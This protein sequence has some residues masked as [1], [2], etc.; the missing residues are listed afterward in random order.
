MKLYI[1]KNPKHCVDCVFGKVIE[2]DFGCTWTQCVLGLMYPECLS[3]FKEIGEIVEWKPSDI[4]DVNL[5][6]RI[7]GEISEAYCDIAEKKKNYG[8]IKVIKLNG[9]NRTN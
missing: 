3:K 6:G 1:D 2:R 8:E 9:Y 5:N 7:K 4:N